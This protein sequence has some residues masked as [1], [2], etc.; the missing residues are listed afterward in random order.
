MA[1]EGEAA[2]DCERDCEPDRGMRVG[3]Q[4][5]RGADVRRAG[6]GIEYVFSVVFQFIK[7]NLGKF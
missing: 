3:A 1:R 5:I 7:L 2:R 6:P 4:K